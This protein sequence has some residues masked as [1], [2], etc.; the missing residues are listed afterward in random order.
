MIFIVTSGR[1]LASKYNKIC[2]PYVPF[3]EEKMAPPRNDTKSLHSRSDAVDTQFRHGRHKRHVFLTVFLEVLLYSVIVCWL[4][5]FSESRVHPFV[6]FLFVYGI[7]RF[8]HSVAD[9]NAGSILLHVSAN[10]G[11]GA[12]NVWVSTN[13]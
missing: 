11:R 7:R 8:Q 4:L 13:S 12:V 5:P 2:Y 3:S 6:Y 1:H 10:L 9:C